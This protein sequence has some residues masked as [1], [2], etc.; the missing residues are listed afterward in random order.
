MPSEDIY[1]CKR[2]SVSILGGQCWYGERGTRG[3]QLTIYLGNYGV[4]QKNIDV[5]KSKSR[6]TLNRQVQQ[7]LITTTW[8][9]QN[10]GEHLQWR[11]HSKTWRTLERGWE[12]MN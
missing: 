3:I 11:R 4:L 8:N 10:L 1:Q 12:R 2:V 7:K 5:P 9:S 6:I